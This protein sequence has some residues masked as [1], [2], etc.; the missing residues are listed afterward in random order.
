MRH[1]PS[2]ARLRSLLV[3]LAIIVVVFGAS[4]AAGFVFGHEPQRET[5]SVLVRE[6]PLTPP[7]GH[8]VAGVIE[9]I[10]DGSM[11]LVGEELSTKVDVPAGVPMDELARLPEGGDPFTPGTAVNL[12]TA[13]TTTGF[14]VTGIVAVG[15]VTP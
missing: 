13:D 14:I 2:S 15:G 7:S 12:G 3:Y 11:V 8:T 1:A 4:L 6:T 10:G 5:V 9:S